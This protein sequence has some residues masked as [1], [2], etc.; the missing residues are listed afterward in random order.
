M[1]TRLRAKTGLLVLVLAACTACRT[2]AGRSAEPRTLGAD[3]RAAILADRVA[4]WEAWFSGDEARLAALL[5]AEL[6]TFDPHDPAFG[7]RADQLAGARA[8]HASGGKLV[9]LAFPRTDFQAYG[10]VAVLATTYEYELEVGGLRSRQSG[11]ATEVF[12]QR[13]GRWVNTY[14]HLEAA[15]E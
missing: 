12:V 2:T 13:D 1:K 4:V 9:H 10:D 5:P 14:W 7:T 6:M 15:P 11:R 3:E 8:F